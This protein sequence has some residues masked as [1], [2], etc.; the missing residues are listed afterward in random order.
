MKI[1]I[2]QINPRV[3]DFQANGKKIKRFVKRARDQ[4]A[5]LV[6]F[7]ELATSGYPP[8]DLL[9]YEYFVRRNRDV[10]DEIAEVANSGNRTSPAP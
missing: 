7:P 5:G 10:L 4:G 8:Q 3:G 6:L 2:A 1:A 9:D